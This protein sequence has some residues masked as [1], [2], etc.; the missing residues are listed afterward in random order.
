YRQRTGQPPEDRMTPTGKLL[1]GSTSATAGQ[2]PTQAALSSYVWDEATMASGD[3][4]IDHHH[5]ELIE[6]INGLTAA[7]A[8]GEGRDH[9]KEILDGL[10][11][12]VG[13]HFSYEEDCME[14]YHCPVAQINKN[15]HEKFVN[16]FNEVYEEFH[17][18]G[19][20]T[21]LLF[22]IKIDLGDWVVNHIRKTDTQLHPC[23]KKAHPAG[24]A[25]K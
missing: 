11:R 10:G 5:Q 21:Q 23:V 16:R 20:S 3:A 18:D 19:P 8:K 12:Y 14:K 1:G 24:H 4:T 9:I 13:M 15:A 25:M 6:M 22:K 2:K 7:M 17:R